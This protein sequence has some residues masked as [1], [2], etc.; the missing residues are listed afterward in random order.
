MKEMQCRCGG[1]VRPGRNSGN[2]AGLIKQKQDRWGG[3]HNLVRS[4]RKQNTEKRA[5]KDRNNIKH[6]YNETK[7]TGPRPFK[8]RSKHFDLSAVWVIRIHP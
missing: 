8:M 4:T 3:K 6:T 2:R 5:K 1:K 7:I